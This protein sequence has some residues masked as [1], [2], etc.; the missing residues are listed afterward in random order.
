MAFAWASQTRDGKGKTLRSSA[1]FL[2]MT[3]ICREGTYPYST[4]VSCISFLSNLFNVALN[5]STIPSV[6]GWYGE[7][8]ICLIFVNLQYF[9]I[10]FEPKF[11]LLSDNSSLGTPIR[12]VTSSKQFIMV[13]VVTF[14]SCLWPLS[15]LVHGDQDVLVSTFIV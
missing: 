15:A 14:F 4:E 2:C 6:W 9:Y 12:A 5:L 11:E 3:T 13:S 8:L 7:V 1:Q 10:T